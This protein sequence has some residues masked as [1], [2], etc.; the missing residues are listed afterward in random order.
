MS[1][2]Y[3]VGEMLGTKIRTEAAMGAAIHNEELP[4]SALI[5]IVRLIAGSDSP[6]DWSSIAQRIVSRATWNR[7]LK[8]PKSKL[9]N[10]VA[11]RTERVATLFDQAVEVWGDADLAREFVVSHQ[12]V[13]GGAP[14]DL[15]A[16]ATVGAR[17]S[18]ALLNQIDHGI[19]V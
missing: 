17:R 14:L 9:S 7:A 19:V 18:A 13:L 11:D 8:S 5:E 6:R 2:G 4:A 12:A 16:D 3:Q 1:V 10:P 15:T